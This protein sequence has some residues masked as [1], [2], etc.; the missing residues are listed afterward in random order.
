MVDTS[1]T[2]AKSAYK[3]E[4]IYINFISYS[5]SLEECVVVIG[6]GWKR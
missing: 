1:L 5:R 3:I 2:I 6:V 4:T